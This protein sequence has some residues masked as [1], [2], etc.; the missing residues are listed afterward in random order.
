M[1]E[2]GEGRGKDVPS[3]RNS[4]NSSSSSRARRTGSSFL[5]GRGVEVLAESAVGGFVVLGADMAELVVVV[6][7]ES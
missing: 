4:S 7:S 6:E 5:G 3:W 2:E 1:R